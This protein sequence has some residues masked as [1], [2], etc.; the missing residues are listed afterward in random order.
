MMKN[1]KAFASFMVKKELDFPQILFVRNILIFSLFCL[2]MCCAFTSYGRLAYMNLH[3]ELQTYLD[4]INTLEIVSFT[5]Y[6]A[7]YG[8]LLH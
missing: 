3:H 1:F 4:N 8:N 2:W 6:F 5:I 7:M